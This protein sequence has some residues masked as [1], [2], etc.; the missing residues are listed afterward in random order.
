[1][2]DFI[3]TQLALWDLA[4]KNYRALGKTERRLF[5]IGDFEGALQFNPARIVSTAAKTD[6]LSISKRPCY[7]CKKNRPTEQLTLKADNGWELLLN[8]YPIFPVH[9]TLPAENHIPQEHFPLEMA[10]FAERW[11]DLAIFFNGA[12]AGASLPDHAHCQAVLKSE[13][14]LLKL[15]ERI[16]PLTRGGKNLIHTSETHASLP[17]H[18]YSAIITPDSEG[19]ATLKILTEIRGTDAETGKP[20]HRLLNVFFW[21][22][23]EGFLRAVIIPRS[24]HRPKCFFAEGEA[25]RLVSPGSIDMAGIIVLPR[26]SDFRN[27]SDEEIA[28]IYS[29]VTPPF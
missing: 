8:P 15:T 16:H 4:S 6:A 25:Q 27:L 10:S 1:M 19:M 14:P 18:Y 21:M 28:S 24:A 13:L 22:G 23:A 17:F 3:E 26:E 5:K 29:E 12:R 7:L 20:D 2:Y 9:F 11:T